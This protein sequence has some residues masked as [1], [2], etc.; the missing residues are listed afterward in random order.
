LNLL[1]RLA[2]R[3]FNMGVQMQAKTEQKSLLLVLPLPVHQRGDDIVIEP[4]AANG[5]RRWLENFDRVT[6]CLKLVNGAAEAG[7]VPLSD[8][9]PSDR[10][11]FELFDPAWSPSR[12][13]RLLPSERKRIRAL[14]EGH[15]YLHFAI[16][17]FWGDWGAVGALI[18]GRMGRPYSVWTDRVESRVMSIDADRHGGLKG[19]YRKLVSWA[20]FELEKTVIRASALGLFHGRDTFSAYSKFASKP[21]LVHDIHVGKEFAISDTALSQKIAHCFDRPLKIIYT[22][23]MHPDKGPIDW[24]KT[25]DLARQSGLKFE[26]TWYGSGPMQADMVREISD[27]KLADCVQLPGQLADRE[28]LLS[29]IRSADIMLFCHLTPESPRCLIEALISGTPI[30]GYSS[31]YSA[32]LIAENGGGVLTPMEP[33]ALAKAIIDLASDRSRLAGLIS[34][35]A[36]DGADFNDEAVFKHRSELMKLHS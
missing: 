13:I 10:L 36:R 15:R 28:K 20:A 24:L 27:R 2:K 6:V 34:S 31:D 26:A 12:F 4:Q 8:I 25:L 11:G 33:S 22:G 5:L 14:I 1:T 21:Y 3:K 23:R 7:A 16:G 9:A 32:D 18:A 30:V 29:A 17:G 19:K 35:A